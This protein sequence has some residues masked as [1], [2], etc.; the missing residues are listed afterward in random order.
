MYEIYLKKKWRRVEDPDNRRFVMGDGKKGVEAV[1]AL[2]AV[3][4][5][6]A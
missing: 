3:K 6:E 4:A 5:I 1:E 2:E